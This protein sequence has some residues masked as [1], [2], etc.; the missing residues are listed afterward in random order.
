M[1]FA[2]ELGEA[3]FLPTGALRLFKTLHAALPNHVLIAADFDELPDVRVQGLNAPLVASTVCTDTFASLSYTLYGVPDCEGC[4]G[5]WK[6]DAPAQA[7]M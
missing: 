1:P 2:G 6:S 7:W 5:R 3:A 4:T